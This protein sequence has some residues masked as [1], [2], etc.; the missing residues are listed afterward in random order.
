MPDSALEC[1][2]VLDLLQAT[3]KRWLELHDAGVGL[4]FEEEA[5]ENVVALSR[6]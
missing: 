2:V 4:M 6:A 3:V 5:G 1:L